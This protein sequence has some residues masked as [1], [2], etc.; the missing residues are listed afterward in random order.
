MKKDDHEPRRLSPEPV[1][2]GKRHDVSPSDL[3]FS[4]RQSPRRKTPKKGKTDKPKNK[5]KGKVQIIELLNLL[6]LKVNR[7]QTLIGETLLINMI[8]MKNWEIL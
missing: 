1:F 6:I 5:V 4:P 8:L 2:K 3:S 7:T